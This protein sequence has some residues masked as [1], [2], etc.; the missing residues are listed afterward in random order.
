M[1]L[2]K[3]HTCEGTKNKNYIIVK[4]KKNSVL[5]DGWYLLIHEYDYIWLDWQDTL[6][7]K[8]EFCPFCGKELS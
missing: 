2:R 1:K 8:I 6:V 3:E 5:G 4:D 7:C